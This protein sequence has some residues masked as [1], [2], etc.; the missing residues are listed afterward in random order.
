MELLSRRDDI[1]LKADF[2]SGAE[3][4]SHPPAGEHIVLYDLAA[5]HHDG[6][7]R[8]KEVRERLPEARVLMFNVSDDDGAIIECV[9]VG[10]AGC[11]LE[12]ASLDEIVA[13]VRSLADG[14][15]PASPRV[16]TSLFRYV[17]TMSTGEEPLPAERLTQRE[18][19]ILALMAEGLTNKE[20]A[21]QVHL[22]P[23]TV[24]NYA[25][26]IFQKLDVHSRL[27]LLR[28]LRGRR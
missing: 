11:V 17:A 4:L 16:I 18:E 8:L 2:S 25:H 27:E 23:Q 21:G 19:Q 1:D 10:A 26:L 13:A 12:D 24:K 5:A 20:I 7:E 28:A 6:P 14:S 15:P 9:Q 3:L 22:Q